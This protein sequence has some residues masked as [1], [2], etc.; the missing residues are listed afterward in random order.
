MSFILEDILLGP[1]C[2]TPEEIVS[3]GMKLP[4]YS[5]VE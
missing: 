3:G 5:I 2:I 4:F 1:D